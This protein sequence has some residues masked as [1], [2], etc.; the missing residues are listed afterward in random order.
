MTINNIAKVVFAM[1]MAMA[2]HTN[3]FADSVIT[4]APGI[5]RVPVEITKGLLPQ[6]YVIKQAWT[7]PK[8]VPQNEPRSPWEKAMRQAMLPK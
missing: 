6:E 4:F 3:A 1:A 5:S 7:E 8:F 2:A